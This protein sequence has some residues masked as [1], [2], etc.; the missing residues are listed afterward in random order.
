[1]STVSG[2]TY[3]RSRFFLG[4][5]GLTFPTTAGALDGAF[6]GNVV[7]AA[8]PVPDGGSGMMLLSMSLAGLA[9]FGRKN[10]LNPFQRAN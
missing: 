2:V 4:G 7:V 5:T 8:A 6:G 9:G 3:D 10:L 1:M